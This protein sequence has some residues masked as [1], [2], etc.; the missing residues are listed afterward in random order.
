M[1]FPQ[2]CSVSASKKMSRLTPFIHSTDNPATLLSISV[3]LGKDSLI[4]DLAFSGLSLSFS[5]SPPTTLSLCLSVKAKTVILQQLR[6]QLSF[7]PILSA[8]VPLAEVLA[9][10]FLRIHPSCKPIPVDSLFSRKIFFYNCLREKK[11]SK[12]KGGSTF[13]CKDSTG[14]V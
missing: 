5:P 2:G 6:A 10:S 7:P 13:I 4:W 8:F 3:A 11:S 1:S 14:E 9:T 12:Q